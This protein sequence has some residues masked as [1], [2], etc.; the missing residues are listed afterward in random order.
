MKSIFSNSNGFNGGNN[1][2]LLRQFAEFKKSIQGRDPNAMLQELL[3]SGRFTQEDV[4]K[5]RE[6]AT[7]FQSLLR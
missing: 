1:T 6:L 4:E 3:N 7:T 2:N 5:A